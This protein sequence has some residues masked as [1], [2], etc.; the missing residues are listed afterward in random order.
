MNVSSGGSGEW[1]RLST[2][3]CYLSV[4]EMLVNVLN[5]CSDDELTDGD[6]PIDEG[7]CLAGS[8]T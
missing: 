6:E 7:R 8:V 4:T 2:C 3:T 5:I 1:Q